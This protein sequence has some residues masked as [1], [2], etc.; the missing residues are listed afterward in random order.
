MTYK[1]KEMKGKV[2]NLLGNN[3]VTFHMDDNTFFTDFVNP[4]T[5][6]LLEE[7]TDCIL[8]IDITDD[9]VTELMKVHVRL[10]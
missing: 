9:G 1:T 3:L 5:Y 2:H 6:E 10:I 8:F 7:G 4:N